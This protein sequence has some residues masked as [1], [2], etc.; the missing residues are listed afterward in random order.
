MQTSANVS[1]GI[2]TYN[3]ADLIDKS[4]SNVYDLYSDLYPVIVFDN[5]STDETKTLIRTRFPN[6][7]IIESESNFGF[8]FGV[9]QLMKRCNTK[10]LFL[11]NP[12]VSLNS[13]TIQPLIDKLENDSG[14]VVCAPT[15]F[16]KNGNPEFNV[17]IFP[18]IRTQFFESILGGKLAN[19]FA[20]SEQ[21]T[22]VNSYPDIEDIDWIKG[23]IWLI[24]KQAFE[25]IGGMRDDFFLY[26]EET[27]FA[28]RAKLK[29]YK[30]SIATGSSATHIG[31][32][33]DTNPLLFSLLCLNKLHFMKVIGKPI[34]LQLIRLSLITG[35]MLRFHKPASRRAFLDLIASFKNLEAS[36]VSI[37]QELNGTIGES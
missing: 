27:E 10:H 14:L 24:N 5:N 16:D 9:N 18:N 23:A 17:R 35:S 30:F 1:I 31:G 32:E 3:S 34:S 21:I 28:W 7:E 4:L 8:G 25:S 36:R 33:S 13:E 37:I 22:D 29:G 11:L 6:V 19:R 2:V 26:S 20:Q 15:T 12:D